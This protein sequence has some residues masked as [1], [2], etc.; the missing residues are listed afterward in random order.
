MPAEYLPANIAIADIPDSLL[1]RVNTARTVDSSDRAKVKQENP[2]GVLL[3]AFE[4]IL[5]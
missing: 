3:E 5:G 2:L 4:V 1:Q